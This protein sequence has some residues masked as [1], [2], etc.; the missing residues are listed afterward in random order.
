MMA[1]YNRYRSMIDQLLQKKNATL[2]PLNQKFLELGQEFSALS[3]QVQ[4]ECPLTVV[5]TGDVATKCYG[6]INQENEINDKKAVLLLQID[7][8]TN[9]YS[10]RIKWHTRTLA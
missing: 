7:T 3:N 4:A 9:E 2:Q 10:E 6:L 8:V 5:W 1:T